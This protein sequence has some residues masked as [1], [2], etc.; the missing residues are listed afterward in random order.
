MTSSQRSQAGA[1]IGPDMLNRLKTLESQLDMQK[2]MIEQQQMTIQMQSQMMQGHSPNYQQNHPYLKNDAMLA[3]STYV[4]ESINPE[5]NTGIVSGEG[6]ETGIEMGNDEGPDV[7]METYNG[8][9]LPPVPEPNITN[10][11]GTPDYNDDF[12]DYNEPTTTN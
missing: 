4:N 11:N 12:D 10:I 8:N 2:Q 9:V 5:S 1:A 6:N 3:A 7:N